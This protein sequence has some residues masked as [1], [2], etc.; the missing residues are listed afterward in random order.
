MWSSVGSVGVMNSSDASKVF[1]AGSI[2]QLGIGI[3]G[4]LPS[5]AAQVEEPRIE[6]RLVG[7]PTTTATLRYQVQEADLGDSGPGV[8]N[9]TARYRDGNGSVVI[10]LMQV[11]LATGVETL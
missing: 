8:W 7:F 4:P 6:E 10:Q 3:V 5:S 9:L 2:A 11:S 1:F